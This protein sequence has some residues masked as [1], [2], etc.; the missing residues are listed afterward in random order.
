[1]SENPCWEK[2]VILLSLAHRFAA[3][4]SFSLLRARETPVGKPRSRQRPGPRGVFGQK[5]VL[6]AISEHFYTAFAVFFIFPLAPKPKVGTIL[7]SREQL[8]SREHKTNGGN[9]SVGRVPD[10]DSGC[11]GFESHFPPQNFNPRLLRDR[12]F[13][14]SAAPAE[15]KAEKKRPLR[16]VGRFVVRGKRT[17]DQRFSPALLPYFF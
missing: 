17:G 15:K 3:R 7:I 5:T 11:R 4:P 6:L 9:S 14:F 16:R 13:S 2:T 8:N 10:C 1:M 12:G